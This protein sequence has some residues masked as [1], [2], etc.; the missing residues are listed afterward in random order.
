MRWRRSLAR[1]GWPIVVMENTRAI[2]AE[3]PRT[4]GIILIDHAVLGPQAGSEIFEL[5]RSA[6]SAPLL[7]LTSKS[8]DSTMLAEMLAAGIDD[9]L[10]DAMDD[11]LVQA[12]INAHL[13][14]VLPEVAKVLDVLMAPSGDI[15]LERVTQSV[16][17]KGADGKWTVTAPL[18]SMETKLLSL[19]MEFPGTV[20]GR[21][22]LLE[23]AWIDKATVVLPGIVDKNISSLRRKLGPKGDQIRTIYGAGYI[24]RRDSK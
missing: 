3:S 21:K 13:R 16:W 5:K 2:I 10:F 22:F 11:R 6:P 20:L 18:T 4:L 24:F 15:R 12:K 14:R 17:L 7:L 8:G 19:F 23:T 1:I 9:Y